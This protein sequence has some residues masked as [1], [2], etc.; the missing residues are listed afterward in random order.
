MVLTAGTTFK[1]HTKKTLNK[2]QS[3][4]FVFS[5]GGL[6]RQPLA[7]LAQRTSCTPRLIL[8]ASSYSTQVCRLKDARFL[9]FTQMLDSDCAPLA[10]AQGQ[11]LRISLRIK[12]C[13]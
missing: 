10:Y 13:G 1:R 7:S 3:S 11:T 8:M 6:L 4:L 5:F 9:N 12:G 2:K